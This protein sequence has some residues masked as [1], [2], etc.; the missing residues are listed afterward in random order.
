MNL[1]TKKILG[2]TLLGAVVVGGVIYFLRKKKKTTN[3]SDSINNILKEAFNN[4]E[5]TYTI[6]NRLCKK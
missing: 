6:V 4:L 1:T 3:N 2:F 5:F